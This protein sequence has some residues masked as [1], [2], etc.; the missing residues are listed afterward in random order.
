M[1]AI[2]A[3]G[4]TPGRDGIGIAL[5]PASSEMREPDGT[6]RYAAGTRLTTDE[7]IK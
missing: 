7:M 4:Y 5:D 3:A 2:A 6:Y 1:E